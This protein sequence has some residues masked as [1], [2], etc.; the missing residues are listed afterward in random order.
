MLS[1]AGRR[2]EPDPAVN[3]NSPST[4]FVTSMAEP[5]VRAFS[6]LGQR[7]SSKRWMAWRSG[8]APNVASVPSLAMSLHAASV[9]G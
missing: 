1:R 3:A 5:L 7:I 2:D 6:L 8:R 9:R 4:A